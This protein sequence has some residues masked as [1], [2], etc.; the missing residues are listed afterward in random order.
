MDS[1]GKSRVP[2]LAAGGIVLRNDLDFT[3]RFA[4]VRSKLDTWGLPKGKLAAGEDA[5][6]AARREVL[7]ET[8]H[9]VT[10]HEF[11]GTL[12]YETSRR[13]KVVQ[14]W[15]MAAAGAPD[16]VLMGDVKAVDWLVLRD[17]IDRLSHL[18]ERVFL[19]QVGP[20]A[21]KRS[22]RLGEAFR[23][24]LFQGETRRILVPDVPLAPEAGW[25]ERTGLRP[26]D[27]QS[28]AALSPGG[29]G[30]APDEREAA[31]QSQAGAC[32]KGG[33]D[34][35]HPGDVRHPGEK[36]LMEKTWGWFRNAALSHRQL[37]D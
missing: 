32:E 34:A 21:L 16:G 28:T 10:V 27:R 12:V 29:Q 3:A 22:H 13:P 17:A 5:L 20:L 9:R 33:G 26:F 7:E 31:G 8:G 14:F 18:R 30:A 36:T 1:K 2:I 15:R 11:L 24:Q 37:F 35:R 25:R 6:T 19:E 4:I 23:R